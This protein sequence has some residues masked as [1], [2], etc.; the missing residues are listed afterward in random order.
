M[1]NPTESRTT[2][3]GFWLRAIE[4]RKHEL[5]R[6]YR[7]SLGDTSREGISDEDYA[8]TMATL[9]KMARNLGWDE[10]QR[11]ERGF[12]RGPGRRH[13][14]RDGFGHP[15]GHRSDGRG[16]RHPESDRPTPPTEA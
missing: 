7:D 4:H 6:D 11:P 15:M 5:G 9:E 3:P 12:G 14:G 16:S 2:R 13:F 1:N 8:T 10:S